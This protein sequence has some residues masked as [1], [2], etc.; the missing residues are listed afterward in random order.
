VSK[1]GMAQALY[2]ATEGMVPTLVLTMA[3]FF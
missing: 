2:A 1:F 3:G